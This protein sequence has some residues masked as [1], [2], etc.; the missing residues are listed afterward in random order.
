MDFITNLPPATS[1]SYDI[2]L[3]ITCKASKAI[4]LVPGTDPYGREPHPE[5]GPEEV[6]ENGIPETQ[7]EVP[8]VDPHAVPNQDDLERYDAPHLKELLANGFDLPLQL[9]N[10][11]SGDF[12]DIVYKFDYYR[13]N[14]GGLRSTIYPWLIAK[15]ADLLARQ[16]ELLD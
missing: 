9:R 7:E 2:L 6:D 4:L 1:N 14:N 16:K 10:G 15:L 8:P 12:G 3:T 13:L 5:P 11:E